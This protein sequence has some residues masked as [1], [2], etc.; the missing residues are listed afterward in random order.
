MEVGL[1]APVAPQRDRPDVEAELSG[2]KLGAERCEIVPIYDN[3]SFSF[4]INRKVP[5]ITQ[6]VSQIVSRN[7][8][9]RRGKPVR[10][11]ARKKNRRTSSSLNTLPS[12]CR[13]M[14]LRVSKPLITNGFNPLKLS[15]DFTK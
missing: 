5:K 14:C 11:D 2:R 4:K 6:P 7:N 3:S 15:L 12:E 1:S 8:T 10:K 9:R 13:N